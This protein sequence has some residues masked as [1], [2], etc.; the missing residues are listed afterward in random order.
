M[1]WVQL[2]VSLM[3]YLAGSGY[4]GFDTGARGVD[5]RIRETVSI[6]ANTECGKAAIEC[7][8]GLPGGAGDELLVVSSDGSN[9]RSASR[10]R[11]VGSSMDYSKIDAALAAALANVQDRESP[12]M[13]VF[14]HAAR[15]LTRDE[16][17]FFEK[18]GVSADPG[19]TIFTARL[20]ARAIE[21]L[22]RQRWVRYIKL[23]QKLRPLED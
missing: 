11:A 22:S 8:A 4:I 23:S 18:L 3:A 21:E 17:A 5:A 2:I 1:M 9:T 20:S 14:I 12:S 7:R 16:I 6:L 15:P 19:K 10:S 13:D